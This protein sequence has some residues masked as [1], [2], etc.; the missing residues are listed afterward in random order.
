MEFKTEIT[1]H[2][3][4]F[5]EII[6]ITVDDY[7]DDILTIDRGGFNNVESP[8]DPKRPFRVELKKP[9]NKK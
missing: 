6:E 1:L 3:E 7:K 5:H 2:V 8:K 4:D 9:L